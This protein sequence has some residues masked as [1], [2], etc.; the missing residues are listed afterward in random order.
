[1]SILPHMPI[2]KGP[3]LARPWP[4]LARCCSCVAY[5]M[6]TA[7]TAPPTLCNVH[8]RWCCPFE[9]SLTRLK[10]A[11]I[12]RLDGEPPPPRCDHL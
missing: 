3:N 8:N 7:H 4:W 9:Y 5:S 11:E 1:V 6:S 10:T 2:R 12:V